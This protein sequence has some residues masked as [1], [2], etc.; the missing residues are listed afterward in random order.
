M[1]FVKL[2][3]IVVCML[4][5]V[6]FVFFPPVNLDTVRLKFY[7]NDIRLLNS[8]NSEFVRLT[9]VKTHH[10]TTITTSPG[11]STTSTSKDITTDSTCEKLL[12]TYTEPVLEKINESI[13]H[14]FK[15][16]SIDYWKGNGIWGNN[17]AAIRWLHHTYLDAYS[18]VV[19]IGGNT[20]ID[21][22][23]IISRYR[24]RQYVILEPVMHYYEHLLKLFANDSAVRVFNF[25]AGEKNM[26]L[27]VSVTGNDGDATSIYKKETNNTNNLTEIL[28]RSVAEIFQDF[29]IC[30][31]NQIDLLTINCEGCEFGVIETLLENN[32]LVFVKNLQ[33]ATHSKLENLKNPVERY[34]RIQELLSKTHRITYQYKFVW[35]S[36]RRKDL[37]L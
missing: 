35:E 24:P 33:F 13:F 29:K 16:Y 20:G 27:N 4:F 34:C 25:G 21:A 37:P 36:W 14:C 22:K 30:C 32:L 7:T 2:F 3:V 9:E 11:Y 8:S 6:M 23:H 17:K 26:R 28:I 12:Q 15:N 18:Y 10:L 5:I 31:S 1:R 19:D